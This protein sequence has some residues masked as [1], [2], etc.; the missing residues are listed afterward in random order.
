MSD[1]NDATIEKIITKVKR[2]INRAEL[3]TAENPLTI[4]T[5]DLTLKAY[6][7]RKVGG[8]SRFIFLK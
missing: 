6:A 5:L 4:D 3:W 8:A 1:E 2:A 7:M